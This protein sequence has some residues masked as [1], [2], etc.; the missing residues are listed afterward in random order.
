MPHLLLLPL[1][2]RRLTAS[3]LFHMQ[4]KTSAFKTQNTSRMRASKCLREHFL[5]RSS[6]SVPCYHNQLPQHWLRRALRGWD[7]ASGDARPGRLI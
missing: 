3:S 7:P 6:I 1:P 2:L 4:I 5:V